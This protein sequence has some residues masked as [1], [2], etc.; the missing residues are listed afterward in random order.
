MLSIVGNYISSLTL[1]FISKN[2]SPIFSFYHENY[3]LILKLNVPL[4]LIV[5]YICMQVLPFLYEKYEDDVDYIAQELYREMIKWYKKF[6]ES[7]MGKIP[8]GPIQDQKSR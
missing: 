7:V 3:S 4:K 1:V 6:D 8:R 5:G 2:S